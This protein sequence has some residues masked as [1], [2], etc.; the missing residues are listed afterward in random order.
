M[1]LTDELASPSDG[2]WRHRLKLIQGAL[3]ELDRLAESAAK[4]YQELRAWHRSARSLVP[5]LLLGK[6]PPLSGLA[7]PL[8]PGRFFFAP[9]KSNQITKSLRPRPVALV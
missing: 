5:L 3:L 1:R 6:A 2:E 7:P 4:E 9:M 8:K